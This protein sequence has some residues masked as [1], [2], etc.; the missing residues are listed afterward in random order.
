MK[1]KGKEYQIAIT[2]ILVIGILIRVVNIASLP[3]SANVDEISSGYEA[4]SILNYGIDRNNNFLPA[5]LVSWGGGQNAL[6][7][8]L[9]IPFIKIFGLSVF[10]IRLPMAILGCISL[11]ILFKLLS[12]IGN[13]KIALIGLAFFAFCPWHIMKSRWGL[14]SNL[15]PD[16]IL[17]FIYLLIKGIEEKKIYYYL[18]FI[19]A[20]ISAYAYG[21]SY[22]FL[23]A[24]IIPTLI[25]LI[26]KQKINIKEALIGIGITAI[27][28]L[29]I[30]LYVIINTFDLKQINLPF[31]TIPKLDVNRY[32]EITSIFSKDF[33]KISI[34]NLYEGFKI[35]LLQTDNLPWNA[36]KYGIIYHISTIFMLIGIV[37]CFIKN[38][39]VEIKYNY[40]FNIW[41]IVSI[42]L[43]AICEPN[44]NR[45]NI[46][47]LPII[48]YSIVGIYIII[49]LNKNIIMP[50]V[51]IYIISFVLF[52]SNYTK[53]NSD[54][55]MTFEGY[56]QEPIEYVSKIE[57][58]Q[59]YVTNQIKEPYIY[60]LFYTKYN[61]HDY[62][63]TVEYYNEGSQF[64]QVKS[65]GKYNFKHIGEL[66]K[67]EENV[68]FVDKNYLNE[69]EINKEEWKI[70]EFE[71]YVVIEG[72]K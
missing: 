53:Q 72:V 60:F 7:T 27:V 59:I 14:E 36:G 10:S 65:F 12:R 55:Y 18:S 61:T 44:I 41:F 66:E 21:T 1:I 57:D 19:I 32:Q 13:K 8:Y 15:F 71:K 24:F 63:N 39:I 52:T 38:K 45:I 70:T 31:V 17:L 9:I 50:I 3:N 37:N 49:N 28:A 11:F 16:L 46:I 20:G 47:W 30:I 54:V 64:E 22:F 67:P 35:I 51:T 23:P 42:I 43:M 40:L 68:Y 2:V 33:I 25:I 48:Y 26:K 34:R 6:L 62:I 4:Y 29:P 56:L 69:S 58:K 5:F